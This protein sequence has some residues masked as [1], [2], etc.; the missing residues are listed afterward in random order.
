MESG[1]NGSAKWKVQEILGKD[2]IVFQ[3]MGPG[4]EKDSATEKSKR[5]A[6]NTEMKSIAEMWAFINVWR[7]VLTGVGVVISATA[8][9][10][11]S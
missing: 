9:G 11:I 4:T 3:G 10:M 7:Y 6:E 8:T 2:E 1:I 5:W